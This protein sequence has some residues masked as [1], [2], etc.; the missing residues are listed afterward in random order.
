MALREM[1]R[2][3]GTLYKLL[4]FQSPELRRRVTGGLNKG[5]ARNALARAILVWRRCAPWT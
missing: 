2:I 1:G 5:E 3:E 4:C